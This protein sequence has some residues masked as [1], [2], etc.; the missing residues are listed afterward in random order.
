MVSDVGLGAAA[1]KTCTGTSKQAQKLA[2]EAPKTCS[3]MAKQAKKILKWLL[4]EELF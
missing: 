4:S 1:P 3:G 2:T